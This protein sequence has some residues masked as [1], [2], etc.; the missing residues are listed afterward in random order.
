[1][2]GDE[3]DFH[4]S[5]PEE[6]GDY[7]LFLYS[8]GYYLEWMRDSWLQDKNLL[9]LH[10]LIENPDKFF[11]KEARI[12]SKYESAME[13]IFWGSRIHTESFNYYE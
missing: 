7:E 6:G 4:F 11:R 12:Y 9:K 1:M 2:P 10:R 3:V 8:K 5:L 13:S